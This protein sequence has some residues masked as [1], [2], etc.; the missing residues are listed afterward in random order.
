[1][2]KN[3]ANSI[4]SSLMSSGVAEAFSEVINNSNDIYNK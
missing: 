2:N 4:L 3:E 1:M